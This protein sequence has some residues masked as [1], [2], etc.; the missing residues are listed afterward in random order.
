MREVAVKP[1]KKS[2]AY[3]R[4]PLCQRGTRIRLCGLRT[5]CAR[6]RHRVDGRAH[7]SGAVGLHC[8]L[9]RGTRPV[10]ASSGAPSASREGSAPYRAQWPGPRCKTDKSVYRWSPSA[11][12]TWNRVSGSGSPA[13]KRSLLRRTVERGNGW[14]PAH[15]GR[16]PCT[17]VYRLDCDLAEN[18]GTVDFFDA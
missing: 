9:D 5:L 13:E 12:V 17:F 18:A 8:A 3:C 14:L 15:A 2:R 1:R 4:C 11:A 6:V 10:D 16:G 7:C